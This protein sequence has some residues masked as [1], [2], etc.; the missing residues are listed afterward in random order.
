[1]I[2]YCRIKELLPSSWCGRQMITDNPRKEYCNERCKREAMRW[3]WRNRKRRERQ[4]RKD[5][6]REEKEK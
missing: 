2:K 1:M 6:Y 4:R 3:Y 5:G